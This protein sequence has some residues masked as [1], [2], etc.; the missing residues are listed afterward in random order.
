MATDLDI[1]NRALTSLG[2]LPA[3]GMADAAKNPARAITAYPLKRDEMLRK[4]PWPSCT[5]RALMKNMNEQA[6]PWAVSTAYLLGERR[7]NDTNKT[8]KV[9]RAGVSAGSGGP[10]GTGA[11]IVDGDADDGV[12]W[13]YVEASTALNNWAHWINTAYELENLVIWDG[14]KV[15]RCIIA[16]TSAAA[17][18][19]TGTADDITDGSV[20]WEYYGSPPYNRTVY[21]YQYIIPSDCLKVQ[22]VPN[23][24]A[25]S[26]DQQGVQY[27]REGTWLYCHQNAGFLQYTRREEDVDR[28]GAL[29]QNAV[30]TA[31]A[32]E[33]AYD[34]TAQTQM[35]LLAFQKAAVAETDAK[36]VALHEGVE[37]IPE[38]PLWEDA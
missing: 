21:L 32:A 34:V 17:N 18:P 6:V 37:S 4:I 20:H 22:K 15:Y 8:Y 33:I 13:A 19:P 35:A 11:G 24:A 9:T 2:N 28:W 27:K 23:L 36:Q 12:I 10:T 14:G 25:T 26:E 7:T 1:V 29:L 16:G 5:T 3:T 38:E 31:I 30:A